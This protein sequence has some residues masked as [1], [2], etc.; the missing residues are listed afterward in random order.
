M[1]AAPLKPVPLSINGKEGNEEI[2]VTNVGNKQQR[3]QQLKQL[4]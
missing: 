3:Q 1:S 2:V 4:T